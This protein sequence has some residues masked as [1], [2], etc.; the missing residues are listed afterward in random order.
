[1]A[2]HAYLKYWLE[3]VAAHHLSENTHTATP[4]AFGEKKLTKLTAKDVRTWL[5]Q[6][7]ITCQCCTRGL[8]TRRDQP[9]CCAVLGPPPQQ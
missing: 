2:L 4:P 9:C 3:N 5:N 7:R 1:M 8:D 6:L